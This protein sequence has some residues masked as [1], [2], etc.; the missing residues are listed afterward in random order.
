MY[1][2]KLL[3]AACLLSASA[4]IGS[5]PA[6]ADL[7]YGLSS[8]SPGTVYTV[9]TTTGTATA[10]VAVNGATVTS[11]VDVTFLNGVLYASDVFGAP[12][13]LDFGTINLVTGAFTGI[14]D[15]GG[16]IN[17]HGLAANAAANLMY[18]VDLNSVGEQLVSV[19][20]GGT[21][22]TI[23]ATNHSINDLAYDSATNTLY[24]VD[25]GSLYTID[26]A[27]GTTTLVGAFGFGTDGRLGL[28]FDS[29][30]NLFLNVASSG[31]LYSLNLGT[32][33]GTLVGNNGTTDGFGIDGLAD[34]NYSP[35]PEP[36]STLPLLLL[37]GLGFGMYRRRLRQA[38]N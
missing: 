22:T 35:V 34:A 33:A 13:G 28:A 23:G 29:N 38:G 20:A 9:D 27:T 25:S 18:A 14:N 24:G 21:I 30:N 32:G 31:A 36:A 17:W 12:G 5:Q 11:L 16:S 6:R 26:T 2:R 19:T 37:G 7:L 10:V 1:L 4:V 8:D 3:G 15:Q